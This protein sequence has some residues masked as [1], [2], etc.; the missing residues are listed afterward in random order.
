MFTYNLRKAKQGEVFAYISFKL[1]NK[2]CLEIVVE[3]ENRNN[4]RIFEIEREKVQQNNFEEGK[5]E[6]IE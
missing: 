4:K 5:I 1:D 6:V 3:E 2:Y